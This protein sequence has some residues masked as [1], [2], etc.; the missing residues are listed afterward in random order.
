LIY[1]Q[2]I[3]YQARLQE[4]GWYLA[5]FIK[6]PKAITNPLG[7]ARATNGWDV[8][9]VP[10]LLKPEVTQATREKADALFEQIKKEY[11][12]TPWGARAAE[13]LGRGY[14]VELREDFDDPRG[15]GIK[16]PVF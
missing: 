9:T 10:R 8:G 1:A 13:E 7:P 15:R 5:E 6:T 16:L 14:G 2:T 11:A 3:S 4:Y 12:G